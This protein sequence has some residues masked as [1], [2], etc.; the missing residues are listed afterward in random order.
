MVSSDWLVS[1][2]NLPNLVILDASIPSVNSMK[3]S[4][5][6]QI[7]IPG[8]RFFDLKREFSDLSSDLP[9]MMPAEDSFAESARNLGLNQASRI[10][11]YD[12]LGIYSS[13][14]VWWMFRAMGHANVAVLDGGLPEWH[15]LGYPTESILE[16]KQVKGDFEAR[17]DGSQ[18]AKIPEVKSAITDFQ[19]KVIDARSPIRFIGIAPEPREGLR[20]GHIPNAINLPYDNV[21]QDGKMR[22][23]AELKAIFKELGIT[24]ERLIFSCGS[25][26]TACIILLAADIAGFD[27]YAVYDGSWAEWGLFGE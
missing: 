11:V 2:F 7:R 23:T 10:V 14:R 15:K 19:T 4:A 5:L 16:Y 3:P 9:G 22:P 6:E 18:V 17:F 12:N 25:G 26:V 8:A 21:L 24:D 27:R 13:P 1:N 20:S